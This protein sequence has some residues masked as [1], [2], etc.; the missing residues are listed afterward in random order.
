MSSI[1]VP[2]EWND[3]ETSASRIKGWI[4]SRMAKNDHANCL[5]HVL[6]LDN[7]YR[8]QVEELLARHGCDLA[9]RDTVPG[10]WD[11]NDDWYEFCADS[12]VEYC[13]VYPTK[14]NLADVVFLEELYYTR[15]IF[16]KVNV[17]CNG[18]WKPVV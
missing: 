14:W 1:N 12:I 16:I 13:G 18:E 17:D 11:L 6:V 7:S 5:F 8:K 15:K 2:H 4:D 3:G 10:C 9:P